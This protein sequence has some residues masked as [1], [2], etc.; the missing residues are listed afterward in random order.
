MGLYAQ[1]SIRVEMRKLPAALVLFLSLAGHALAQSD[2]EQAVQ[3]CIAQV[4]AQPPLE[5]VRRL[6][7]RWRASL[8]GHSRR[9]VAIQQMPAPEGL[10]LGPVADRLPLDRQLTAS[11]WK[12]P[13]R[14]AGPG[15]KGDA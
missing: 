5:P 3:T 15:D 12:P 14:I 13:L 1:T 2:R 10:E 6:L 7:C 8:V 4:R 9:S 11:C